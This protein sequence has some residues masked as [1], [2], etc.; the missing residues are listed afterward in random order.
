MSKFFYNSDK[1][2]REKAFYCDRVQNSHN[3]QKKVNKRPYWLVKTR[4]IFILWFEQG[5]LDPVNL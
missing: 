1:D 3:A 4:H 5:H 2:P